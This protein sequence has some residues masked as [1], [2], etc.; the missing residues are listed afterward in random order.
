MI[1]LYWEM[2]NI[3]I[4]R[5]WRYA[6]NKNGFPDD[7]LDEERII[8]I[9]YNNKEVVEVIEEELEVV[10]NIV[11]DIVLSKDNLE[12]NNKKQISMNEKLFDLY[13]RKYK[14]ERKIKINLT[15]VILHY[16]YS[17]QSKKFWL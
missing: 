11:G 1:I 10:D 13:C 6:M 2:V 5:Y 15:D 8:D 9:H 12:K 16:Y 14:S 17:Y 3:V 4:K 7:P